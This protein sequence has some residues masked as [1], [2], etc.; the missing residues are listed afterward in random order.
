M[1]A[2]I[3]RCVRHL[4]GASCAAALLAAA[5]GVA[6]AEAAPQTTKAAAQSLSAAPQ[7]P[8]T[9]NHIEGGSLVWDPPGCTPP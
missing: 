5:V 7:E 4:A 3:R 2:G 9:G 1:T 6:G 8:C